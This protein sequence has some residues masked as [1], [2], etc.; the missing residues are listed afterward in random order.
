MGFEIYERNYWTFIRNLEKIVFLRFIDKI[1]IFV[2]LWDQVNFNIIKYP[3]KKIKYDSKFVLVE[4][5]KFVN[6]CVNT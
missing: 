6:S 3:D 5:E 1:P 2:M 4:I